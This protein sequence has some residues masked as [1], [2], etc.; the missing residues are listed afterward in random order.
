MNWEDLMNKKNFSAMEA[1]RQSK[2]ANVLMT[3]ELSK[4][5]KDTGVTVYSLHPG[6]VYTE[7]GRYIVEKYGVIVK[8]LIFFLQ[9]LIWLFFKTPQQGAQTTIYCAVDE[10]LKNISGH[11]Y[12]DC[13]EKPLLPHASNEKDAEKLW[14]ISD[15]LV[16]KFLN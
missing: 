15:E 6:V 5:L 4:K 10:Q 7:M 13:K 14:K 2:L 1:Y 8:I 12:S 16:E 9:P 3:V 11:Y